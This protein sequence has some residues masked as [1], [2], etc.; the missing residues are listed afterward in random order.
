MSDT[1]T[2]S[3]PTTKKKLNFISK[4]ESENYFMVKQKPLQ[5]YITLNSWSS[6]EKFVGIETN[7]NNN[8]TMKVK[9]YSTVILTMSVLIILSVL[10]Y[11]LNMYTTKKTVSIK[12]IFQQSIL[13]SILR[14]AVS[15]EQCRAVNKGMQ[16]AKT[17]GQLAI[18]H[19]L[20]SSPPT[21]GSNKK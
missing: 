10:M 19:W 20:L 16:P 11:Q 14:V 4:K 18:L 7:N 12:T 21:T 15:G 2:L 8:E 6:N 13:E 5:I 17:A 3:Q 1:S 9:H